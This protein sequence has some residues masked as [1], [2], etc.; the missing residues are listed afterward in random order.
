MGE[1]TATS[2]RELQGEGGGW[3]S[4]EGGHLRS[5]IATFH[6]HYYSTQYIPKQIFRDESQDLL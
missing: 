5:H 6:T 2:A 4:E 1:E 3:S